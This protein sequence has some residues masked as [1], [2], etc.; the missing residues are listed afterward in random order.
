MEADDSCP[1]GT[2]KGRAQRAGKMALAVISA[3]LAV[4]LTSRRAQKS[5]LQNEPYGHD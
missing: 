4:R 1:T 5:S 3:M 2:W